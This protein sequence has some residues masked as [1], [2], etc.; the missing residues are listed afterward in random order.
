MA[1]F[2][3][4]IVSDPDEKLVLTRINEMGAQ[5]WRAVTFTLHGGVLFVL[6]ET[7]VN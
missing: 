2:K 7:E 5:G 6:M 4:A 1:T 3:Y